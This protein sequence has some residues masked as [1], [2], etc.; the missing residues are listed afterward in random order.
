[1]TFF[2]YGGYWKAQPEN[3]PGLKTNSMYG[4]STNQEMLNGS[5]AVDL[6]VGDHVFLRPT[7]SEHVMLQFGDLLTARG[8]KL[9]ETWPVFTE[10]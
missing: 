5:A 3:P 2:I 6:D 9:G 10:S 7:Q 8:G 4:R 1:Q